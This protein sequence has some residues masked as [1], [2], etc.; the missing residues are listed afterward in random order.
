MPTLTG[1]SR[2]TY[3]ANDATENS[4]V[5]YAARENTKCIAWANLTPNSVIQIPDGLSS[6]SFGINP[7]RA[8]SEIKQNEHETQHNTF[9][10]FDGSVNENMGSNTHQ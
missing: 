3:L 8:S 5:C 10:K 6:P 2:E 9:V 1:A 4:C 7:Q